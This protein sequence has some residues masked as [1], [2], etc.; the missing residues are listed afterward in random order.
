MTR[1]VIAGVSFPTSMPTPADIEDNPN[2][3]W[4]WFSARHHLSVRTAADRN[5]AYAAAFR[6]AN[7]S[8]NSAH[9]YAN[10]G[11]GWEQVETV[12]APA[13]ELCEWWPAQDAPATGAPGEGCGN[14]AVLSV[15]TSTNW[16]LCDD[17][18]KLPRFRR[19][20]VRGYLS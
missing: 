17:C 5:A 8:R 13:V 1:N 16:H 7:R 6:A 9:V 20:S 15:G 2:T 14:R 3:V 12:P 11:T 10:T 4:G 19:L 18:R